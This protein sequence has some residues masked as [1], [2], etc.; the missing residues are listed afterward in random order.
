MNREDIKNIIF[1]EDIEFIH[2]HFTDIF[3][4]MKKVTIPANEIERALNNEVFFDGSSIDGFVREEESEMYLH[5]DLDTFLVYP[6]FSSF[7]REARLICDIYDSEGKPFE[8]DPRYMLKKVLNE[9]NSM[10]YEIKIAPEC[11]FF[12]FNTDAEGKP[13]LITN[14]DASYFDLAPVDLGKCKT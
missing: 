8:G 10:G 11:E 13:T 12:L 7:G 4:I 9:A 5:P 14:D 6:W 3:G 1:N 2:L